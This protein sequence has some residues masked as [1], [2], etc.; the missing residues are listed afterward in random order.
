MFDSLTEGMI[1]SWNYYGNLLYGTITEKKRGYIMVYWFV[2]QTIG[3]LSKS[4]IDEISH[5]LEV[6]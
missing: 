1:I 4:A 2:H 5:S 3:T 6:V